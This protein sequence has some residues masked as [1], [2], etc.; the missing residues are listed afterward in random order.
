MTPHV[1]WCHLVV[2]ALHGWL[3]VLQSI[4]GRGFLGLVPGAWRGI[5]ML[6]GCVLHL[7]VMPSLTGRL[8]WCMAL[9]QGR[10]EG[11]AETPSWKSALVTRGLGISVWLH[12]CTLTHRVRGQ[13]C[14]S[15]GECFFCY[16]SNLP[17]SVG[18]WHTSGWQSVQGHPALREVLS[19]VQLLLCYLAWDFPLPE[20]VWAAWLHLGTTGKSTDFGIFFWGE[21]SLSRNLHFVLGEGET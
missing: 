5:R 9:L 10:Q 13:P 14:S 4:L 8:C 20:V 2:T 21:L 12:Q 1:G 17:E 11:W 16:V 18:R 6:P 19:Y 7:C 15:A 3:P